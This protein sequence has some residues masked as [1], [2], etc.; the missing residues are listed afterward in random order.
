M[1]QDRATVVAKVFPHMAMEL[2]RSDEMG[3]LVSRLVKAAMFYGRRTTFEE[4]AALK[5]PFG[6][7]KMYGY[8]SSSEKEF[9]ATADPYASLEVLLSKKT[10][11]LHAKPA[12]STS[13]PSSSKALLGIQNS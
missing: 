5:E 11:S 12:L 6:L 10:K 4:V 8:R 1:R 3:F 9:E 7:E 2:I 13:N